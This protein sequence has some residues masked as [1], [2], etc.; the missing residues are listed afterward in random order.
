MGKEPKRSGRVTVSTGKP[1]KV[2]RLKWGGQVR[3][4]QGGNPGCLNEGEGVQELTLR[5]SSCFE[6]FFLYF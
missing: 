4:G 5:E 2:L 3:A 1:G 6:N